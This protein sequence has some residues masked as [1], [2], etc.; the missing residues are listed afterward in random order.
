MRAVVRYS[1]IDFCIIM[2]RIFSMAWQKRNNDT[3]N[4]YE[5]IAL[6]GSD[7]HIHL[8]HMM[9]SPDRLNLL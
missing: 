9:R 5:S 7:T 8:M 6:L 3:D 1:W 4:C 2:L